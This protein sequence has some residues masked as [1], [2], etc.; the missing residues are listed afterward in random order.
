MIQ[1]VRILTTF[2]GHG[3]K[4]G[5]G[6]VFGCHLATLVS[7]K[8]SEIYSGLWSLVHMGHC[9]LNPCSKSGPGMFLVML[10]IS[11]E[12]TEFLRFLS[13][14]SLCEAK[15]LWYPRA[16]LSRLHNF[17]LLPSQKRK[18]SLWEAV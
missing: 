15:T 16:T 2:L 11:A 13:L 8:V 9:H 14:E 18:L 1:G 7:A 17:S 10:R 5:R 6:L 3:I 12:C 4:M